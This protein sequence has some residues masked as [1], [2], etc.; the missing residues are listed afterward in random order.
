L[1]SRQVVLLTKGYLAGWLNFNHPQQLSHLR[2]QYIL[3]QIEK[4]EILRVTGLRIAA[5][6][7]FIGVNPKDA[8]RAT[9]KAI[10]DYMD[11]SLPYISDSPKKSKKKL[12]DTPD[13]W[14]AVIDQLN[15]K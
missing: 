6:S 5:Q 14:K 11:L 3:S 1:G 7:Q 2:E 15:K 4:N 13:E 10:N 9:Q 8:G 12:P